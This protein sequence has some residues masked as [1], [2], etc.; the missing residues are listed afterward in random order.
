M[1][2]ARA[3]A[4]TRLGACLARREL[5]TRT[6]LLMLATL[7]ASGM[8]VG[9][10]EGELARMASGQTELAREAASYLTNTSAGLLVVLSL[11]AASRVHQDRA[12]KWLLPL[13]TVHRYSAGGYVTAAFIVAA[14]F[15]LLSCLV[16]LT[17]YAAAF[18]TT[19]HA[20][21]PGFARIAIGICT[22]S[23]CWTVFGTA[24]GT[25]TRSAAGWMLSTLLLVV[26]PIGAA[27]WYAIKFDVLLQGMAKRALFIF[28]P[29]LSLH[30]TSGTLVHH[31][32]YTL[33]ALAVAHRVAVKTLGRA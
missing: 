13:L 9:Q 20:L 24:V 19:A 6:G 22:A 14:A 25:W 28:I 16:W 15:G 26:M 30:S 1:P 3:L 4:W 8:L 32:L 27:A 5:R 10:A 12:S 11:L 2:Q 23:V 29:A 17:T 7:V 33:A 21:P 31:L 18:A